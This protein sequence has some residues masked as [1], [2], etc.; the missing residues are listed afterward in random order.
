MYSP[1]FLAMFMRVHIYEFWGLIVPLLASTHIGSF[2]AAL[3][4]PGAPWLR[5]DPSIRIKISVTNLEC[6]IDMI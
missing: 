4:Q 2:V 5:R 6:F 1:Y 3:A